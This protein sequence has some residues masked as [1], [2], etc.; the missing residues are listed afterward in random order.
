MNHNMLNLKC[1]LLYFVLMCLSQIEIVPTSS[2]SYWRHDT[3]HD[4]TEHNDNQH[5]DTQHKEL[6][7][8]MG[9]NGTELTDTEHNIMLNVAFD[10]LLC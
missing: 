7:C 6:L 9:I 3:E 5:T 2:P 4:D 8:G 1:E 10:L